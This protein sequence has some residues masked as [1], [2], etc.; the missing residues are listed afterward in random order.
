[1]VPHPRDYRWSSYQFH[2]EGTK[3]VLLDVDPYYLGLG[4]TDLQRQQGYRQFVEAG[5]P[6][7]ELAIIRTSV[8]RG[9]ITAGRSY[10]RG[11]SLRLSR[12]LELR[13]RGRPGIEQK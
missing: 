2:G 5:N 13:P 1:M 12:Q 9:G 4:D 8:Q 3:D 11:L 7:H 6:E 10:I